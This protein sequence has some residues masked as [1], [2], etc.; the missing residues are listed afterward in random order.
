MIQHL[1]KSLQALS[2]LFPHLWLKSNT[3]NVSTYFIFEI[4]DYF[5][6]LTVLCWTRNWMLLKHTR[7]SFICRKKL[8]NIIALPTTLK[9]YSVNYYYIK[10][11]SNLLVYKKNQNDRLIMVSSFIE[12]NFLWTVWVFE[13]NFLLIFL[14]CI[15]CVFF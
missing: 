4:K 12:H 6:I 9:T 3:G 8:S 5:C 1:Y 11:K 2:I 15:R 7:V 14:D 10:K 13:N